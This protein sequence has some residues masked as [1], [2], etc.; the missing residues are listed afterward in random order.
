MWYHLYSDS[1]GDNDEAEILKVSIWN[2]RGVRQRQNA[3]G[4]AKVSW[5]KHFWWNLLKLPILDL[6]YTVFSSQFKNKCSSQKAFTY[7][8][9]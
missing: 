6:I 3:R 5:Y 7:H 9:Q 4:R 2:A 1:N 8:F